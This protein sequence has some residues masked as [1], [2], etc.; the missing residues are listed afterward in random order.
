MTY[1]TEYFS[2]GDPPQNDLGVSVTNVSSIAGGTLAIETTNTADHV[3]AST[4]RT[5]TTGSGTSATLEVAGANAPAYTYVDDFS[6][7]AVPHLKV[8][9]ARR[10]VTTNLTAL[11]G[12]K[13][14]LQRLVHKHWMTFHTWTAPKTG[15]SKSWTLR[16][17]PGRIRAEAQS[18]PGYG[19]T[20]S[21]A[22]TVR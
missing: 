8:T 2:A 5:F 15:W 6:V 3:W 21:N 11:G 22:V 4:T 7:T 20:I 16:V 1:W 19:S 17:T 13:V 10:S 18:A 12:Q 9:V 14:V